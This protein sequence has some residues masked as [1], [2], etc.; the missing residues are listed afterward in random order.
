MIYQRIKIQNSTGLYHGVGLFS[1]E[2]D[3]SQFAPGLIA[4]SGPN[5]SGKTT[6]I[7]N[8]L[9]FRFPVSRAGSLYDHFFNAWQCAACGY[10]SRDLSLNAC[11][12]CNGVESRITDGIREGEFSHNEHEYRFVITV[13]PA[14]KTM[15]AYLYRDGQPLNDKLAAYDEAVER[16]LIPWEVFRKSVFIGQQEPA[17]SDAG[18]ADLKKFFELLVGVARYR[19][20][21]APHNRSLRDEVELRIAAERSRLEDAESRVGEGRKFA[22]ALEEFRRALARVEATI[23]ERR[24]EMAELTQKLAEIDE[25]AR[26]AKEAEKRRREI[27][28][29][30]EKLAAE[31]SRRLKQCDEANLRRQNRISELQA[32]IEELERQN[33]AHQAAID[34]LRR[35]VANSATVHR[36][37]HDLQSLRSQIAP[38]L[39]AQNLR[40][41]RQGRIEVLRERQA[42]WQERQKTALA[43]LQRRLDPLQT[44]EKLAGTVPCNSALY[45]QCP[46]FSAA[47][48]EK[49]AQ[50]LR[51][52]IQALKMQEAPAEFAAVAE[53]QAQLEAEPFDPAAFEDLRSRLLALEKAGWERTYQEL[54]TS[55][56]RMETLGKESAFNQVQIRQWREEIAQNHEQITEENRRRDEEIS[57]I[58][59]QLADLR[60]EYAGIGNLLAPAAE[61]AEKL[62]L[63]LAGAQNA[64]NEAAILQGKT[65]AE[66][67]HAESEIEKAAAAQQQAAA[68]RELLSAKLQEIEWR[69]IIDRFLKDLPV[70][71]IE[72]LAPSIMEIANDLLVEYY[73]AAWTVRLRTLTPKTRG[74]GFKENFDFEVFRRGEPVAVKDLSVG[75]RSMIEAC[76]RQAV[77][78]LEQRRGAGVLTSWRDE[79]DGALD[80]ENAF[81]YYKILEHVHGAG[82]LH[83]TFIITHRAELLRYFEQRIEMVPGQGIAIHK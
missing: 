38:L 24:A 83:Q 11:P 59:T 40:S 43:E 2:L 74:E 1:L 64:A 73:G 12:D 19:D 52:E 55:Q 16:I 5:G 28:A 34:E 49:E 57:A 62:R 14:G 36:N 82:R 68:L 58:E 63:A 48:S 56:S 46:L 32:K 10:N 17:L 51:L 81:I 67:A 35:S 31:K 8:F 72:A 4:V 27:Q 77:N 15:T 42:A 61:E 41:E 44:P 54:Q 45:Q 7:E 22:L 13:N 79:A 3:L 69:N 70:W 23:I 71:E 39:E 47:S 50:K 60:R 80:P 26:A 21:M 66:I 30:G 37:Y 29:A 9:P 53:L 76:L 33:V 18:K 25:S 20:E 78:V 65:E 6:L 75:Q